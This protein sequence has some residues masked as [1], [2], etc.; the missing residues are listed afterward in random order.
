M[1]RADLEANITY[2]PT[3]HGG[4]KLSVRSGYRPQFYYNGCD[5]AAHHEYP[6]V[7]AVSPGDTAR[8]FLTLLNPELHAGQIFAGMP[9]LIREG[10]R[11]V[12]Y[13]SVSRV[14]TTDMSR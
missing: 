12:G 3:E 1:L 9:F 4:K 11:I 13:G 5:F 10:Q 6:D 8:V 2:I 7:E 14:L